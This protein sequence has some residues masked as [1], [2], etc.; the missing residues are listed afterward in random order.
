MRGMVACD[1]FVVVE[2][3]EGTWDGSTAVAGEL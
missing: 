3:I 2:V 1:M